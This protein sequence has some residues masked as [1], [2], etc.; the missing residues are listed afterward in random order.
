[1]FSPV[2]ATPDEP[3][4]S[5]STNRTALYFFLSSFHTLHIT[6]ALFEVN[7]QEEQY[8]LVLNH[9]KT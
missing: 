6:E 2:L 9:L 1:M 7:V 8:G 3:V 5:T 4:L